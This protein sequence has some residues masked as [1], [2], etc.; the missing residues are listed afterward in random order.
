[1]IPW[2]SCVNAAYAVGYSLNHR[3]HR[4]KNRPQKSQNLS[5]NWL[6]AIRGVSVV[7]AEVEAI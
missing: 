2:F 5:S 3:I 4:T 1:M 6:C 7:E